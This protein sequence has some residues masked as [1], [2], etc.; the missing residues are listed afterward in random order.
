MIGSTSIFVG[1]AGPPAASS[2]LPALGFSAPSD[3][4]ALPGGVDTFSPTM[5]GPVDSRAP[6][7]AAY[8]KQG[9]AGNAI[10]AFGTGI[11]TGTVFTTYGQTSAGNAT[12][13]NATVQLVTSGRAVV[14]LDGTLPTNSTIAFWP[15]NAFGYGL[16]VLINKPEAYRVCCLSNGGP[17]G[18]GDM[19]DTAYIIGRNMSNEA[20][21]QNSLVYVI[22]TAGGTGQYV[23]ASTVNPYLVTFPI[24]TLVT[25]TYYIWIHNT[26]GGQ[27]GWARCTQQ[28]TVSTPLA[29]KRNY[30][31]QTVTLGPPRGPGLD[32]SAAI[33]AA[34]N[35]LNGSSIRAAGTVIFQAGQTYLWGLAAR[36][37]FGGG[38]ASGI[39][40]KG[41][42]GS[43]LQTMSGFTDS[44]FISGN[45][46]S[47]I[48]GLNI[49]VPVGDLV[50]NL[51]GVAAVQNI[52]YVRNCTLDNH[53]MYTA[54]VQP[55]ACYL[56]G[57]GNP[58]LCQNVTFVGLGI[59]CGP[60]Y[61]IIESCTFEMG[62]DL[63]GGGPITCLGAMNFVINN[64]SASLIDS[65]VYINEGRFAFFTASLVDCVV[66]C[67][68][69]TTGMLDNVGDTNRGE[70]VA[71]ESNRGSYSG[72]ALAATSNSVTIDPA[73]VAANWVCDAPENGRCVWISAG[74]GEGF[75]SPITAVN[76][77]TGELG[78]EIPFLKMP[79]TTSRVNIVATTSRVFVYGNNFQVTDPSITAA[80]I[81]QFFGGGLDCVADKNT[82]SGSSYIYNA[83][84]SQFSPNALVPLGWCI[85]ENGTGT[86]IKVNGVR[87]FD[88]A[89]PLTNNEALG[90]FANI[91][92]NNLN[93]QRILGVPT[94]TNAGAYI[95]SCGSR[96]SCNVFE[97]YTSTNAFTG[98]YMAQDDTTH[99]TTALVLLNNNITRG[100]AVLSGSAGVAGDTGLYS[101]V[102]NPG[103]GQI[104]G[105]ASGNQ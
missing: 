33:L 30:N 2:L 46:A 84:T 92:R 36:L 37:N 24:P 32:D 42:G 73:Q 5:G 66:I 47:A 101:L 98:L 17:V 64:C 69:T 20:V 100:G 82:I 78:L 54:N 72:P 61:G 28:L 87:M 12:K 56:V 86:D 93:T 16:P 26:H 77:V 10:V 18:Y 68:N 44:V 45:Y 27:Y 11:D 50:G 71:F 1:P 4:P 40:F 31:V 19:T 76:L 79:D 94:A 85:F 89:F 67:N 95:Q 29:L 103:S 91:Y 90:G 75:W 25:G 81:T 38:S 97:G 41:S 6:V 52:A 14:A 58:T 63:D 60:N 70:Q 105:F 55:L 15:K 43:T 13:I 3:N 65:M 35:Q 48:D 99:P 7:I 102:K 59:V 51:G 88:Y 21:T 39:L 83:S 96:T 53:L 23:T 104:S 62:T 8:T 9:N 74:P 22:S 57:N 34:M 80:C 49:S